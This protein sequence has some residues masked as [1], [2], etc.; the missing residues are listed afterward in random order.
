M[1]NGKGK[2]TSINYWK[3]LFIASTVVYGGHLLFS[4][5]TSQ[6]KVPSAVKKSQNSAITVETTV[7]SMEQLSFEEQIIKRIKSNGQVGNMNKPFSGSV[8]GRQFFIFNNTGHVESMIQSLRK[9]RSLPTAAHTSVFKE[10]GAKKATELRF[11]HIPK[12]GKAFAATSVHYCCELLDDVSIGVNMPASHHVWKFDP[13]CRPCLMQPVTANGDYFAYF[14]YIPSIDK[15]HIVTLLREPLE[16]LAFQIDDMR[17]LRSM[18][19]TYG[20]TNEDAQVLGMILSGKIVEAYKILFGVEDVATLD[21]MKMTVAAAQGRRWSPAFVS[22]AASCLPIISQKTRILHAFDQCRFQLV[23]LFPGLFGC[24]TKL[25]IGRTCAD[26]RPLTRGDVDLAKQRLQH[27]FLF[28][29]TSSI[30]VCIPF[31][32][33]WSLPSWCMICTVHTVGLYERWNESVTLF[34]RKLG[35]RLFVDE[36]RSPLGPEKLEERR[37]LRALQATN[38]TDP[39]DAELYTYATQLFEE[40]WR[41]SSAS[42]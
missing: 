21:V 35:G 16:R 30:S 31:V 20:F 32:S 12:A 5:L 28:T 27:E 4:N 14:P 8:N 26:P 23:A 29:G 25:I 1:K 24:Q 37:V 36:L 41:T 9:Y 10:F 3:W 34:H 2:S 40:Q 38:I 17:H 19:T 18:M 6:T 15:G 22:A 13:S 7:Q 11:L 39:F 42:L 33:I